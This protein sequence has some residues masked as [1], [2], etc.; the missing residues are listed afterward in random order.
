MLNQQAGGGPPGLPFPDM[1]IKASGRTLESQT[2]L[3][4][5]QLAAVPGLTSQKTQ[6]GCP[7]YWMRSCSVSSGS[8]AFQLASQATAERQTNTAEVIILRG[9]MPDGAGC[10]RRWGTF[11]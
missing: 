11:V 10:P 2:Q 8:G 4:S 1:T 6:M 7:F 9:S 5:P 3:Y